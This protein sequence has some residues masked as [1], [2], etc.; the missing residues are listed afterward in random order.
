MGPMG[1]RVRFALDQ[2]YP[3]PVIKAFGIMMPQVE[4]VAIA[5]ID[6]AFAELDDWELFL[7]LHHS[8]QWDGLVTNDDRLLALPK[9][10][11][12]LSQTRLTLVIAKGERDSPVRSVG[13]LLAHLGHICHHT[14]PDRAQVWRLTV[15]QK[16]YDDPRMYLEKIA[17]K[18]LTTVDDLV[19]KHKLSAKELQAPRR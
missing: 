6:P 1:R 14:Q 12:V 19:R 3:A 10:M 9:E 5:D 18:S 4:L 17:G 2:N 8:R 11:T 7:A 13:L 16:N 15:A